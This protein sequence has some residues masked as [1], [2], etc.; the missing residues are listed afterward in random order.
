MKKIALLFG[1]FLLLRPVLPLV[2]YVVNYD[3]ISKVLCENKAKPQL[4]CNGKCH[5]MKQMAKASEAEKPLS[6]DK[7]QLKME[8]EE[9]FVL[10]VQL[11]RLPVFYKTSISLVENVY[12]NT[13]A[14]LKGNP[15]FHPPSA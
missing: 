11:F 6:Q 4:Q 7:K 10:P 2:E 5:L 1:L 13:Y 3:Y 9:M 8:W 15:F 14:F 12:T